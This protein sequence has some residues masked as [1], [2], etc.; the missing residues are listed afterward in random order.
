MVGGYRGLMLTLMAVVGAVLLIACVNLANLLL[1]RSAARRREMGIRSSLGAGPGRLIRQLLTESV[2]L[3]SMGALV[4]LGLAWVATRLLVRAG[5]NFLPRAGEIALDW[6]VLGFT[7]AIAVLTGMLFGIAPAL[8][9]ARTNLASAVREGGRGNTIGFRRNRLR[10][11]LVIGE[12]ALALVLLSVAGLLMRSFFQLQSADP[13]FDPHQVLT[14]RTD[15]PA[16]A[17]KTDA[18]QAAF[19]RRAL[20]RIRALPGVSAA[21]AAQIF[22]LSH[23]DYILDFVQIG[24]PPVP[25]GSEPNAA[26]YSATDGYR[27]ALRIP[28]KSGR[29]FTDHDDAAAPPVAIISETMARQFYSSE[30]PLGQR[31]QMGNGSKPAEIVGIVGDVRDQRLETKGLPAVYEPAA[32][33]PFSAMQFAVRSE[34]DPATLISSVRTVMRDLDS[35]LPLDA[36]GT[37]DSLVTN[38]LSVNRF[39]MFLMSIFAALALALAIVGIYGV[40]SYAVTQANQEIGIRMAL[41]A[42]R[43]DVL[44]MVLAHAGILIGIGLAIG[45]AGGLGAGRLMASDL[46]EVKPADPLTFSAVAFV[47]LVTGLLACAIPALRAARVDP[48]TALREE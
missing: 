6:R 47:L 12:V 13:G 17:Y 19:Y 31:I 42:G 26:Y 9:L 7:A 3:A 1:S 35:E 46:F 15:L 28:L 29:D 39:A 18:Q 32:Q 38:S 44:R 21:G 23:S 22:P 41:G 11:A 24:K 48:L 25:P 37:V 40:L 27:A 8:H 5:S 33:V 4:G 36:E 2:L 20:D 45:M 34:G 14:F 30:N 16:S 43:G 10:S